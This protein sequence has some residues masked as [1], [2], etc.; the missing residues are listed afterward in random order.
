MI[1]FFSAMFLLLVAPTIQ[2]QKPVAKEI[3]STH[4]REIAI[5]IRVQLSKPISESSWKAC[6]PKQGYS[7]PSAWTSKLE[8]RIF[9]EDEMEDTKDCKVTSCA[10]RYRPDE[11]AELSKTKSESEIKKK[12][13]EFYSQR[14]GG[15][16]LPYAH[17]E[18]F[19]IASSDSTFEFC[20]SADLE[21]LLKNRTH[22]RAV[23]LIKVDKFDKRMRPTTRLTRGISYRSHKSLCWAEALVFANH[24]DLDRVEIWE[25][26]NAEL[27]LV[28]RGRL[29]FFHSWWRRLRKGEIQEVLERWGIAETS[30]VLACLLNRPPSK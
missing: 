12:I 5:D 23:T 8:E 17:E 13:F 27:R 21:Q 2:A 29:D 10:F 25:A 3:N 19:R 26:S 15:R 9:A 4:E 22:P 30:A 6:L 16:V 18:E 7:F 28:V 24:Y 14:A 11:R 1:Q 20:K